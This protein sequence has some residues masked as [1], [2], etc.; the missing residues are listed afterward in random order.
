MGFSTL[1][2]NLGGGNSNI[3]GNFTPEI[4]GRWTHFDEHIFQMGWFNHQLVMVGRWMLGRPIFRGR[5]VSFRDG[6]PE[7][8]KD[9]LLAGSGWE[10]IRYNILVASYHMIHV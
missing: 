9:Q 8:I 3:F 1:K 10:G 4:L 2:L 7:L 6:N 5:T